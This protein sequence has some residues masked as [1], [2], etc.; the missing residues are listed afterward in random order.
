[1]GCVVTN[2][3]PTFSK[4]VDENEAP[5]YGRVALTIITMYTATKESLKTWTPDG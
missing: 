1:M 3:E 5:I 4:Y 2:A